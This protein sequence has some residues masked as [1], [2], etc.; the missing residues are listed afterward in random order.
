MKSGSLSDNDV[1]A[2]GRYARLNLSSKS[3]Y[4]G[5][6]GGMYAT[7]NSTASLSKSMTNS[8]LDTKGATYYWYWESKVDNLTVDNN[9]YGCSGSYTL[10]SI[11]YGTEHTI[12]FK[13]LPKPASLT[14]TTTT[15]TQTPVKLSWQS[16]SS[17]DYE[18]E[19][20]WYIFRKCGN[21][22][23]LLASN[24]SF[25]TTTY[26]DNSATT[27]QTYTYYIIFVPTSWTTKPTTST[28]NSSTYSGLLT[29]SSSIS[30]TRNLY[31][32]KISAEAG[33]LVKLN[34][35][36]SASSVNNSFYYGTSISYSAVANIGYTFKQWN[37]GK[38]S[39]SQEITV[40]ENVTKTASFTAN[41][42]TLVLNPNCTDYTVKGS[43]SVKATYNADMPS[44]TCPERTGYTFAGY[45]SSNNGGTQ[46]YK[47]DGTSNCKWNSTSLSELFARWIA[48]TYTITFDN[49]L[50]TTEGTENI[51]A[52][53][54]SSL[55]SITLPTKTGYTFQGYYSGKNGAGKQ[56]YTSTGTSAITWDLAS[57]TTL[58]AYWR[59]NTYTV[60]FDNQS[61]TTSG[62][63]S[64]SV[65]YDLE[66][67][68]IVI[69]SKIGFSF[70]GYF[71]E[72][73]G[74]GIQYFESNGSSVQKSDI[75]TDITLY[76]YWI[77]ATYS[78][79]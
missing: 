26:T 68:T 15:N 69:P 43:S 3:G 27:E 5:D 76:S 49:Q 4:M 48:N 53:Y 11:F 24:I 71:T 23:T 47:A 2:S 22:S 35:G 58:Y 20:Y 66:M 52:T 33:G 77:I 64:I 73:N 13:P 44:I 65:T 61:A 10:S 41:E 21:T 1:Y 45:W 32:V 12:N 14:A 63:S 28:Y 51:T 75:L 34:N 36:T 67:P 30:T 6:Q 60:T 17:T 19:G 50:A 38:T 7:S 9:F 57:N 54:G 8:T 70:G 16:F 25:G 46:Y 40:T 72:P 78:I 29:A 18:K 56:Y 55:P 37:D 74:A 42:Y 31:E 39:A 62:T 79:T 59:P